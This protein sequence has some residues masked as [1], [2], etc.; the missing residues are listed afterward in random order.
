M[1]VFCPHCQSKAK[2]THTHR[3]TGEYSDLY[4]DCQNPECNARFVLSL[5]HKYDIVQ[6][7]KSFDLF[8]SLLDSASR[9]SPADR[10]ALQ[11]ALQ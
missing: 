10:R 2:I 8:S 3:V 6:P 9:L 11:S 4:A 1:R 7:E 5:S